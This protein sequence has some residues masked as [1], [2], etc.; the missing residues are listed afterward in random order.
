MF[1][2]CRYR[3]NKPSIFFFRASIKYPSPYLHLPIIV[4]IIKEP[5]HSS[6]HQNTE[7]Q[8]TNEKAQRRKEQSRKPQ[9]RDTKHR[10]K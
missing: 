9:Q 2:V 3:S 10:K 4:I 8:S 6:L 1:I 5:K 7:Q